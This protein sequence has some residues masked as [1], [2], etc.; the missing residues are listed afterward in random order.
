LTGPPGHDKYPLETD[1]ELMRASETMVGR[2]HGA[3]RAESL[4]VDRRLG[5]GHR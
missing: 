3:C 1:I 5:E 2:L 4:D